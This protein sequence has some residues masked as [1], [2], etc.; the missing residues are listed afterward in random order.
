MR[1]LVYDG[2]LNLRDDVPVPVIAADEAL[3]RIRCAGICN[4]DLELIQGMYNFSGVPGH[5]FVAEV[6]AGPEHLSGKR[7]V[8]EINIACGQCDFCQQGVFSQCRRR[9]ALGIRNQAGV[10][11]DFAV[12]P[13]RNLHIVPD[14]LSDDQAVFTEPLAAALQI[15]EAVHITPQDRVLVL[16]VG[17]LGALVAQAMRLTGAEVVGVVRRKSQADLLAHWG[18][19]GVAFSELEPEQA[20]VVV[21]CTGQ[22]GGFADALRLVKAR[23]TLVLKST[24]RGLPEVDMTQIAVREIRVVGSR[25]GPFAA[26]LRLLRQGLVDVQP[27]IAARYPFA[28]ILSA[29]DYAAKPGALKVLVDYPEA[30]S[31]K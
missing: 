18:I 15:L 20:S 2:Q 26:A 16:G 7:V 30:G 3:L 4:S 14:D 9:A 29:L 22:P 17:K 23:G 6:V 8:G 24:Y 25:C 21:E 31:V 1:A 13:V 10:F 12:L 27:L 5:E 19:P 11:A 28:D